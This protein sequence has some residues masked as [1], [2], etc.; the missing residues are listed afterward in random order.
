MARAH[1]FCRCLNGANDDIKPSRFSRR[2]P[3][4]VHAAPVPFRLRFPAGPRPRRAR[5]AARPAP[6][7]SSG[8]PPARGAITVACGRD[9]NCHALVSCQALRARSNTRFGFGHRHSA[10]G[11][12]LCTMYGYQISD[13][14]SGAAR[15]NYQVH[16]PKLPQI[17][18]STTHFC[19]K[20]SY[21]DYLLGYKKSW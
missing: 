7:L 5:H 17:T 11:I 8:R 1:K 3:A 9:S 12:W 13:R 10:S 19:P 20:Y 14:G 4:S 21:L 18:T 6:S 16:K 2:A 15:E